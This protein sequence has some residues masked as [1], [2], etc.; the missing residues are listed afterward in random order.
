MCF[1]SFLVYLFSNKTLFSRAVPSK[2][3]Q[4]AMK[5]LNDSLQKSQTKNLKSHNAIN[6][7]QEDWFE[8]SSLK[9]ANPLDVEDY[10]DAFEDVSSGLLQ[11]IVNMTDDSGNTAMH[12]AVSHGNF[13]VVSILLDS[14]VCDI[15]KPNKAGYTSVMLVS[16]AEV[17]SQTH[18][19]VVKRLF[20]LADVNIRAKQVKLLTV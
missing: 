13:D 10:L 6:I 5:V 8:I 17:N 1:V 20:Q 15:N 14:K 12:Y 19:N 7:I 16:L 4:G 18:A 11:Y 9:T 3:M 2:E